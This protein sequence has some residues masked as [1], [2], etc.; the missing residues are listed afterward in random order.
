MHPSGGV[1]TS[2]TWIRSNL[3]QLQKLWLLQMRQQPNWLLLLPQSNPT[4]S[5]MP[6]LPSHLTGLNVPRC[7]DLLL[8]ICH[9]YLLPHI[10]RVSKTLTMRSSSNVSTRST[11]NTISL[12]GK[13]TVHPQLL[14]SVCLPRLSFQLSIIWTRPTIC[15]C[16]TPNASDTKYHFTAE[17][18]HQ[19]TGC[20]RFR[21]YHHLIHISKDGQFID[22]GKFPVSHQKSNP[23]RY[24]WGMKYRPFMPG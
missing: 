13:P 19:L 6:N 15:P 21:N 20:R 24:L 4:R 10:R 14:W 5:R 22:N 18:L 2:R 16:N 11:R 1:H 9:S 12:T 3:S 17:E 8:W 7:L 23:R